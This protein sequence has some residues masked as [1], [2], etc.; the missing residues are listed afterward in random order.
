MHLSDTVHPDL[1]VVQSGQSDPSDGAQLGQSVGC[2][3]APIL[4]PSV[5]PSDLPRV[6]STYDKTCIRW[7]GLSPCIMGTAS[8]LESHARVELISLELSED[9]D[10]PLQ[11][12]FNTV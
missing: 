5:P 8:S 3:L 2:D 11:T 7:V 6:T 10:A 1:G 9:Y 4:A 12:S